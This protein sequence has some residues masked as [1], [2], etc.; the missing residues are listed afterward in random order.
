MYVEFIL[1]KKI[2]FGKKKD[3][4]YMN[5]RIYEPKNM[6]DGFVGSWCGSMS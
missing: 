1:M 4:V 3:S 2:F 5:G 6:E